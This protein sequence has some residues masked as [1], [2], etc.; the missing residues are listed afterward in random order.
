M[1]RILFAMLAA[2]VSSCA[3]NLQMMPRDSGKIYSGTANDTGAGTGTI[4][5]TIDDR[6]YSGT[7]TRVSSGDTFGFAQLYG[8]GRSAFG[9]YQ[10]F[11][12]PR[13]IK[14]LMS[15][16]DNHGLRCDLTSDGFGHGGGICVDDTQRVFDVII[17]L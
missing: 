6:K 11:G 3:L 2:L 8:G 10:S 9:T 7:W 15:S 17:S 13:F 14:A 4:S 12:G 5:V 16:P 1:K